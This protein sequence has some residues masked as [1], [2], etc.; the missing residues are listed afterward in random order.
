MV[1]GFIPYAMPES[2]PTSAATLQRKCVA[3]W[4]F[5]QPV[6]IRFIPWV[7]IIAPFVSLFFLMRQ[8][9]VNIPYLDDF[10]FQTMFEKGLKGFEWS[11][12]RNDEHLTLHDFFLVQMEHRMA[13]V[14]AIIMLR[15]YLSPSSITPQNWFTLALLF[16]TAVNVGILCRKTMGAAFKSWWPV[17]ALAC[18][19]IF[20]PVQYQVVLWAL[21]F[22]VAMPAFALSTTLVA[23]HSNRLPLWLKWTIGVVAAECATNCFAAGILVWLLPLPVMIWGAGFPKGKSRWFYLAAWLAVFAVTMVLYMHDLHNEV[24]GPYAYKQDEVKTMDRNVGAV[25]KSPSKAA[26]FVLHFVGGTLG[27]GFAVPIMT[28]SYLS[29]LVSV[30]LLVAGALFWLRKFADQ[31]LRQRLL[32]WFCFGTYSVGAGAMVAMGRVWATSNGDNAISPRY[33]IHTVPLTVSLVAIGFIILRHWSEQRPERCLLSKRI[34]TVLFTLL[35][36]MTAASWLHGMRLMETWESARLRMATNTMFFKESRVDVQGMIAPNKRKA[37][38]MDG[39]GL[40]GVKMTDSNLANQF[41]RSKKQLNETSAC[42]SGFTINT[43]DRVCE[44]QGYA[45]LRKRHR[46]AD[47]VFLT[48]KNNEGNWVIFTLAQVRAMPLFLSGT[49][50]RD[51]QNIHIPGDFVEAEGLSGFSAEFPLDRL[52]KESD[53]E[54]AAW[55]FD[56]REQTAYPMAGRFRVDAIKGIAHRMD[57][58]LAPRRKNEG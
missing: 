33:T 5:L 50:G 27:R 43:I 7:V 32:P 54:V 46:V 37:A 11:L 8:H 35:A 2:S 14:R 13:F 9:L 18:F 28:L 49:L 52:P 3:C 17:L 57:K 12:Q 40:L 42:W 30:I 53:I 36:C 25:L 19:L 6:L 55:A 23:L 22:Q 24:D 44:A 10:M 56:Y 1:L 4:R 38:W 26:V 16:L 20:S 29:G 47:G 58:D 48:Y 51:L 41:K 34:G 31:D 39:Q 45:C 21:M 15:H